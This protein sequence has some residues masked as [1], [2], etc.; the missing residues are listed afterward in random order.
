MPKI[1][2]SFPVVTCPHCKKEFQVED[3]YDLKVDDSF[4][5]VHCEKEI[6]IYCLD[7]I[8]ECQLSTKPI[9]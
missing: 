6:Y 3:Y 2:S 7:T 4:E 5:C 8:M 1:W 9:G